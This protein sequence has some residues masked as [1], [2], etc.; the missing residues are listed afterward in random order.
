MNM[1]LTSHGL[2]NPTLVSAL[3]DMM[4]KPF[5]NAAVIVI[6]D[7]AVASPGHTTPD[8]PV[9]KGW[10]FDHL[11]RLRGLGW[12]EVDLIAL[13]SVPSEL[14]Q[15]RLEHAD[16]LYVEGGDDH[17]L[18]RVFLE[19]DLLVAR[20]RKLLDEKVYV[21]VSAGSQ[22]FSRHYDQPGVEILEEASAIRVRPPFGLFDWYL[23]AHLHGEYFPQ[24]DEAWADRIASLVDFPLYVLDDESAV[25]VRGEHGSEVTDVVGEGEWR[26]YEG[27]AV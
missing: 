21:G 4:S 9:D 22:I 5:S 10:V 25:R 7:A 20:F 16:V 12:R 18:A 1:L 27:G 8:E 26:F 11:E 2:R 15:A 6:L 23:K 19:S 13:G 14:A 17:N 3:A 24:R